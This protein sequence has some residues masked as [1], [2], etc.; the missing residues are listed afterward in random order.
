M[1]TMDDYKNAIMLE[2]Y[3]NMYWLL[4]S[5]MERAIARL[6]EGNAPAAIRMLVDAQL[7]AEDVYAH[8]AEAA[9]AL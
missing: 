1:H 9:N 3:Q 2:A 7:Q 8:A 6:E 4:S 5:E